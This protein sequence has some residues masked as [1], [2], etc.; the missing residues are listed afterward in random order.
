[1]INLLIEPSINCGDNKDILEVFLII[2]TGLHSWLNVL[3]ARIYMKRIVINVNSAIE[4]WS[5]SS[6]EKQSY[7]IMTGYARI[8]RVITIVQ[9]IIG[10]LA[11]VIYFTT[12]IIQNKQQVIFYL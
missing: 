9:L 10:F 11:A 4:D 5:T 8:G 3:F 1:M 7:L 2:E 6:T 12:V